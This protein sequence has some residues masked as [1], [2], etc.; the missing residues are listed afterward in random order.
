M[1][2]AAV[3][4][5]TYAQ[6]LPVDCRIQPAMYTPTNPVTAEKALNIPEAST[7]RE[8]KQVHLIEER[9]IERTEHGAG[10]V[11]SEVVRINRHAA[12]M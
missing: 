1:H 7:M 3:K 12:M 5:K 4:T 10:V 9:G 8:S 6:L 2:C 11:R